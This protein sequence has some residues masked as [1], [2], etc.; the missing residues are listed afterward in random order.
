MKLRQAGRFLNSVDAVDEA[1]GHQFGPVPAGLQVMF[2]LVELAVH[3]DDHAHATG[4]SYR[5]DEEFVA[6]MVGMYD[7]VFGVP[8]GPDPWTCLLRATGR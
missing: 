2:G 1:I 7:T 5:P 6:A 4:G 3:H 8:A